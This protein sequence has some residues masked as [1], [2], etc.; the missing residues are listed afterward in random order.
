MRRVSCCTGR[1]LRSVYSM[2]SMI[3]LFLMQNNC[4]KLYRFSA[5]IN[6]DCFE[7]LNQMLVGVP[8]S[9]RVV[10]WL[11]RH[12]GLL[13]TVWIPSEVEILLNVVIVAIVKLKD[14]RISTYMRNTTRDVSDFKRIYS[15]RQTYTRFIPASFACTQKLITQMH[16]L[17]KQSFRRLWL[18]SWK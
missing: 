11:P 8:I 5:K 9:I 16:I 1:S 3:N 6:T 18:L 2:I 4:L 14:A 7:Y 17:S 13:E 12:H 15:H 10:Q